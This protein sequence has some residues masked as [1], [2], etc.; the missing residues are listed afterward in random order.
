MTESLSVSETLSPELFEP[1]TIEMSVDKFEQP[2]ITYWQATWQKLLRNPKAVSSLCIITCLVFITLVGPFIWTVDPAIQDLEQISQPPSW[3]RSA[4]VVDDFGI[5]QGV[6]ITEMEQGEEDGPLVLKV[7]GKGNTEY[8]RLTWRPI[9]GISEYHIYRNEFVPLDIATLGIPLA[10]IILIDGEAVGYE[11]RLKLSERDYYYSV[12]AIEQVMNREDSDTDMPIA[13]YSTIRVSVIQGVTKADALFLNLESEEVNGAQTVKLPLH[14]F[15]TDGLGRDI[16]SRLM[17][18]AR[19]SLLIGILAPLIY[20]A[21]G[22]VYGGV[23]GYRGGRTDEVM[24]RFADFVIALPF[25]LFMILLKVAFGIGP[26]ESGILPMIIALIMLGW[27]SVARIVRGQT[28]VIKEE[29]YIQAARLMGAKPFYLV[30]RHVLPNVLPL[31]I[32]SLTFAIPATIFTE[33]FLSFI[34]FGVVPPNPSWGSMCN[35]G[36]QHML[37]TPH[38]LIFPASVICIAV[39]CFNLLGGNDKLTFK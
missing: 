9:K 8:V 29:A 18:G 33:A 3:G 24:M 10:E 11:D 22:V 37:S 4:L 36:L 6:P 15:G 25:L 34:G 31:I 19:T 20:I 23:S 21:M 12:V 28:F 30:Y 7:I 16:L 26:G 17:H 5:W 1:M 27:P 35:D 39:L 32:V 14:P 13:V 38:E 2:S